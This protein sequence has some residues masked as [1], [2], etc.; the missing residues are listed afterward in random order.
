M[1]YVSCCSE[2]DELYG[3]LDPGTIMLIEGPSGVGKTVFTLSLV[4]RNCSK[5]YKALYLVFNETPEKLLMISTSL[6]KDLKPFLAKKSL[7]IVRIPM[8]RDIDLIEFITKIVSEGMEEY[9]IIVIDSIT[10][11]IKLLR[12]HVGKRAW[13]QS[14]LYEIASR[15]RGLLILVAD[16]LQSDDP[17]LKLLEYVSD[18][19]IEFRYRSEEDV[20]ERY[21]V[22]RKFRGREISLSMIPFD[23]SSSGIVVLNYVSREWIKKRKPIIMKI[24][25][26]PLKKIIP[27]VIDPGTSVFLVDRTRELGGTY[28]HRWLHRKTLEL[29]EKGYRIAFL[30]LN[31]KYIAMLKKGLE[32]KELLDRVYIKYL[33]PLALNPYVVVREEIRICKEFD[34][35]IIFVLDIERIYHRYSQSRNQ[36]YKYTLYS[37]STLKDMNVT[38]IRLFNL[39]KQ[40]TIPDE[41]LD[42]SDIVIE[43]Q[44]DRYGDLVLIPLKSIKREKSVPIRDL[45]L[46]TCI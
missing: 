29:I 25:C 2:L 21:M 10:P 46:A 33:N 3:S 42:W 43:I 12:D 27:E 17:D 44:R 22:F 7:K 5:G 28:F 31:P 32:R 11:L 45:D 34:T 26:E 4:H 18:I 38:A 15:S 37:I 30:C 9:D 1:S 35:D 24:D 16:I 19:V 41:F 6:G 39:D 20:I 40:S 13:L 14:T 8:L 23:I 36:L